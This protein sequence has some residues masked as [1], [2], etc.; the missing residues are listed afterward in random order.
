M[1]PGPKDLDEIYTVETC[2]HYGTVG[3]GDLESICRWFGNGKWANCMRRCLLENFGTSPGG[4]YGQD[5]GYR[6]PL[7][8]YGPVVHAK[9]GAICV[10]KRLN[11]F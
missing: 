10:G 6:D 5:D 1:E 8:V 11:P 4:V 2:R 7:P 9:C 3:R